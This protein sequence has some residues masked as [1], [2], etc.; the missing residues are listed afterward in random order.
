MTTVASRDLR[1]H[2]REILDRVA[3]GDAV[4]I[5]I[6]GKPVAE[7]IPPRTRARSSMPLA[8]LEDLL[9]AQRPD[10]T[11]RTDL[12]WISEGSTDDLGDPR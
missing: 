11:L 4:T 8:E 12:E 7:L 3:E 9:R 10:A 1:N 6:N 2:T 5:T